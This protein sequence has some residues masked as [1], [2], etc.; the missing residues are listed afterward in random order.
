[1]SEIKIIYDLDGFRAEINR[2]YGKIRS[3]KERRVAEYCAIGWAPPARISFEE[4]DLSQFKQEMLVIHKTLQWRGHNRRISAS[5]ARKARLLAIAGICELIKDEYVG[6]FWKMY[7]KIIGL[8]NITTVYNWIWGKGFREAGIEML[9]DERREFVQTLVMESGVPKN[10]APDIISFFEIYWRYLLGRNVLDVI[11]DLDSDI[12]F[13]HIPR[14]DRNRLRSLG[15]TALEYTRAFALAVSR[16][17]AVFEYISASDDIFGGSIDK[18]SD[19]IFRATGINP[20]TYLRGGDQLRRL[21]DKIL[22]I[23]T[24]EKLHRIMAAKPPG[25]KVNTPDGREIRTDH[26]ENIQLGQHKIDGAL[27]ICLPAPGLE[28]TF[29]T[30]LPASSVVQHGDALILRSVAEIT[31]V[32]NGS[33]RTDL[34]RKLFM[35]RNDYGHLFFCLKKVAMEIILRTS[36]GRVDTLLSGK[37]GFV[38]YPYLYYRGDHRKKT[39][40]ISVRV[41]SIRLAAGGLKD[42]EFRFLCNQEKRPLHAGKIDHTGRATCS[43]RSVLLESPEPGN[44]VFTAADGITGKT[45]TLQEGETQVNLPLADVML[46]APYSHRQIKPRTSGASF[47]F[48]SKRFVLY[49]ATGL[50]EDSLQ[51]ENCETESTAVVGGYRVSSLVWKSQSKPCRIQARTSEGQSVTWAFAKCL[52]FNLYINRKSC[53]FPDHVVFKDNQGSRP[54]DFELVLHPF[55]DQD[56]SRKLFWN[57]IVNDSSPLKAPLAEKGFDHADNE[58][59]RINGVD[60]EEML[61]SLWNRK[62]KVNASVEISLCAM[63]ETLASHR[64]FVFPSLNVILPDGV[65]EGEKFPVQVDLGEGS[66][67]RELLLKHIR[68]RSKVKVR[69]EYKDEKW[70]LHR[71]KFNGSLEIEDLETSIDIEAVPP[72]RAVRFGKRENG[73]DEP[74]RGIFKSE[75]EPYDLLVAAATNAPPEITVNNEKEMADFMLSGE[76]LWSLPLSGLSG[77]VKQENQVVVRSLGIE[78]SFTVKYRVALVEMKVDKYLIDREVRGICS[79]RGPIGSHIKLCLTSVISGRQAGDG[80]NIFLEPDGNEVNDWLFVIELPDNFVSENIEYYELSAILVDNSNNDRIAHEYG[81]RWEILPET[82]IMKN[83]LE[84]LKERISELLGNGKPFA[85]AKHLAAS[86]KLISHSDQKWLRETE[87]AVN[88]MLVKTSLNRVASQIAVVL[89]KEYQLEL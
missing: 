58:S 88:H 79:F 38:C 11:K 56:I 33:V 69:F 17:S 37:D 64:S 70:Q 15:A 72:F 49:A 14:E 29:L 5:E 48:G 31:P 63:D 36:D 22:G 16:L 23:V 18:W 73:R 47:L 76:G 2:L 10:R 89:D 46:F 12:P 13:A 42:R 30:S 59:L 55:P 84:Y 41:N 26:Y 39:H 21:Y 57:I 86:K 54:A 53:S 52:D 62:S 75:L 83:D 20:L 68:G 71:H 67:Y 7:D 8:D 60:L 3:E 24:P 35:G 78:K 77:I 4:L 9:G 6:K 87:M 81:E 19:Q 51:F 1:M 85:A 80:L 44:V 45:F 65:Q 74:V 34:V 40:T 61:R 32:V 82:A 28:L 43:E 66:N 27:F 25:T 50:A